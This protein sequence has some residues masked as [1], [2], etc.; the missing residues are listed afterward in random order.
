MPLDADEA[1]QTTGL[2]ETLHGRWW[3]SS[4]IVE[5]KLMTKPSTFARPRSVGIVF[6]DE[7]LDLLDRLCV[8]AADDDGN[9]LSRSEMVRRLAYIGLDL[10]QQ[11]HPILADYTDPDKT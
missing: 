6:P 4:T 3:P 1:P 2:P 11:N 7:I 8:E 5:A 9:P 10:V